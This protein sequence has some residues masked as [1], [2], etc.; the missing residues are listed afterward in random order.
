MRTVGPMVAADQRVL[1]LGT[2]SGIG[3]VVAASRGAAVVACDESRSAV[4]AAEANLR[5]AGLGDR[6]D[7]RPGRFQDVLGDERFDLVW[8]NGPQGPSGY[9]LMG[10]VLDACPSWLEE[11]GRLVVAVDRTAGM[12]E[13]VRSRV[14]RGYRVVQ[15]ARS[16]ELLGSWEALCIGWDVEA[17]RARRH[18]GRSAEAKAE[19]SRKRWRRVNEPP[20]DEASG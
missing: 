11:T 1:D 15:L 8:F 20:V 18:S 16:L 9:R 4:A 13:F 3:A 10:D 7:L 2:G 12:G 19:V 6:V 17:A 5:A 14:P